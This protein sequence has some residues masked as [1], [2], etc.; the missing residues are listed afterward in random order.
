[1]NPIN[2]LLLVFFLACSKPGV[3]S[4]QNVEKVQSIF[5][6]SPESEKA[7]SERNTEQS[8]RIKEHI[9]DDPIELYDLIYMLLPDGEQENI[10]SWYT[11]DNLKA[12]KWDNSFVSK[13]SKKGN[14]NIS[15]EGNVLN[16]WNLYFEGHESGY[17]IFSITYFWNITEDFKY[18]FDDELLKIFNNQHF[19]SKIIEKENGRILYEI[20]FPAKKVFWM[21]VDT[22]DSGNRVY[23]FDIT[24]YIDKNEINKY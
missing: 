14:L 6:I 21:K 15:L 1:M 23:V 24:V 3:S 10:V 12:I 9:A 2:L 22:T 11:L 13:D 16:D 7:V 5:N 17:N 19:T 8:I 18:S 4:E 20:N